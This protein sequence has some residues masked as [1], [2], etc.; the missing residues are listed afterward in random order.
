M[1]ESVRKA[2]AAADHNAAGAPPP[3]W[4]RLSFEAKAAA[5]YEPTLSSL[6][7]AT[8]LNHT[9]FC[10]ALGYQLASKLAGP[11]VNA[12]QLREIFEEAY[13]EDPSIVAAGERDLQAILERDPA[14]RTL[15]QPFMFFKGYASL[16]AYRVAHHLWKQDRE[17][18]SYLI[19]SRVSELFQVD[20]HPAARMGAGI[21][22][23]HA[24]GVV[25]GETASVGDDCSILH[26]VNLGGTGKEFGDR[27]PK[28]GRGVLLGAGAKVLGP[29]NIGDEARVAASS[30]VL[31][32][33]PAG[34][35]V[36]G[37]P[38]KIV[39]CKCDQPAQSMDHLIGGI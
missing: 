28:I 21:F 15:L 17:M 36:A 25:I 29:I 14:S 4:Q 11:D 18:L 20:I 35:T 12:L 32:D 27:H 26:E 23:D 33:V 38:A 1:S 8:I 10:E 7:N 16:Q 6:I 9:C 34:C 31:S 39:G 13:E 37:V 24:T 2:V 30:V 5:E 19:Q 3:V 22:M